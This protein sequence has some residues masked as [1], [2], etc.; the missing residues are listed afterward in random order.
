MTKRSIDVFSQEE[1]DTTISFDD[2]DNEQ[3]LK[4]DYEDCFRLE[5]R[6]WLVENGGNLFHQQLT[7]MMKRP[8]TSNFKAKDNLNNM[9]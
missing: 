3:L 4:E 6:K 7:N 1:I 8:I 2:L 9:K 5:C